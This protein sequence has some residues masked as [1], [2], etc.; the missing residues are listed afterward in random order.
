MSFPRAD[1]GASGRLRHFHSLLSAQLPTFGRKRL[2]VERRFL[3][4]GGVLPSWASALRCA[5]ARRLL[6][7]LALSWA[8]LG[9]GAQEGV[10][11]PGPELSLE[12][13]LRLSREYNPDF[14][15]QERQLESVRWQVRT[16]WGDLTPNANVSNSYGYQASGFRR[17]GSVVLAEQPEY[18]NSSYNMNL[19]YSLTGASLLRPTQARA[20]QEAVRARVSGA[21][22][23]LRAE[24][25]T[26]YL[27]VLQADAQVNQARTALE[28]IRLNVRQA[29]AQVQ[30][31][32]ATPLDIRRAEVQAGQAEVQWV[33][34][35]NQ[36]AA[37]RLSL[38]RLLGLELPEEVRLVTEFPLLDPDLDLEV[39]LG[40][41]MEGNPVLQASRMNAEV[42]SVGVRMARTQYLPNIGISAGLSASVFQ[43]RDIEPLV[44]QQLIQQGGRFDGC[45]Q[46]NRL[47]S[48]L[49][50][51]PRDCAALNPTNP[52]VVD[53]IRTT[54]EGQNSGF[55]F[56]YQ[57]QPWNLSVSFSFPIFTGFARQQQIE[58][59][60]VAQANAREQL[61][62]EELRLRTE[63]TTAVRAVQ[64]A[65]RT[66]GLQEQIR[67]TAS[68]ELRLAQERFRLGL[69]SSIEVADAQANLSQAERDEI[70]ARY[71]F[72]QSMVG[73]ESLVG[74][75]L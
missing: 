60:R 2:P 9:L 11:H 65:R 26:A 50:D 45:I 64:T 63:I 5:P 59:A 75:P 74:R 57:R 46:D 35:E 33:Q 15:I 30:V 61:R 25:T 6:A 36:A 66:V 18:L 51:A 62:S 55:P 58:E 37:A 40:W 44:S 21:A 69:A 39:L 29:E 72:H 48:L 34:S 31:G 28:R 43:A 49:G 70:T 22:M 16:A 56:D 38:S 23:G 53:Q 73:L 32:A 1:A 52:N 24:V 17:L 67:A 42:A 14:R 12:E 8:P 27:S 19:S 20:Q 4:S 41:A 7:A 13:A 71:T 47:R 3:L 68:E 10:P 54:L